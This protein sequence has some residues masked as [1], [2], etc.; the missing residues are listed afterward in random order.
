MA[1]A[2]WIGPRTC[3]RAELVEVSDA[4]DNARKDRR[5]CC[6]R[7]PLLC[8]ARQ[9]SE[10]YLDK[11]MAHKMR[12]PLQAEDIVLQYDS[13]STNQ[14][15]QENGGSIFWNLRRCPAARPVDLMNSREVDGSPRKYPVPAAQ[16]RKFYPR[17]RVITV[18]DVHS[19][20]AV[21]G[22]QRNLGRR[23]RPREVKRSL[24]GSRDAEVQESSESQVETASSTGPT[25][26][27]SSHS[28]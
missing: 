27:G 3:R 6:S 15:E 18:T 21:P 22:D 2:H 1:I 28:Q 7:H 9:A 11:R 23:S 13:R 16:L 14:I 12:D 8:L 24:T 26:T 20:D 19:E 5:F 17:G 10:M 4:A 25:S